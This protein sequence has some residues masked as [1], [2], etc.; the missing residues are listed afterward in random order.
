ME[1]QKSNAPNDL[2]EKDIEYFTG[3]YLKNKYHVFALNTYFRINTVNPV[4]DEYLTLRNKNSYAY[5]TAS[6]PSGDILYPYENKLRNKRLK[7]DLADY[8][9]L[10]GEWNHWRG[11]QPARLRRGMHTDK[12]QPRHVLRV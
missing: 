8:E 1:T 2:S 12:P 3:F 6:D 7:R 9:I 4:I 10:D 11:D 5:L